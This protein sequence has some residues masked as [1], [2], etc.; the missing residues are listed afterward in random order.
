MAFRLGA[1]SLGGCSWMQAVGDRTPPHP[2][3]HFQTDEAEAMDTEAEMKAAQ[4]EEQGGAGSRPGS[5][6]GAGEAE[7]L[8]PAEVDAALLKQMEEMVGQAGTLGCGLYGA[9]L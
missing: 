5:A 4:A 8:V 6:G 1:C 2:S 3:W 7:E 9:G